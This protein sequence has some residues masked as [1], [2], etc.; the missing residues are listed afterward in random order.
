VAP[1]DERALLRDIAE[2]APGTRV[3]FTILRNG[4]RRQVMA[5]VGEWPRQRWEQVDAPIAP[6]KVTQV[7][8]PDL[9][10]TVA[11]LLNAQR[12]RLGLGPDTPGILVT[13][14][15]PGTDAARRGVVAGDAIL[16]VQD[17]VLH[18][19]ADYV[20]AVDAVR[21]AHRHFALMLIQPLK[22]TRP[23]PEWRALQIAP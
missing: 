3:S 6:V 10:L 7:I 21:A 14:V 5:T 20:P 8:P 12:L 4:E 15:A 1:S 18:A 22:Q 23:G 16:R 13:A 2:T 11:P 19:P 17:R 9:G